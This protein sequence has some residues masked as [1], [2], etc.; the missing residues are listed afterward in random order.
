MSAGDAR[1]RQLSAVKLALMAKKLRA[2]TQS[3]MRAEPIA[4]VGLGCR[5]PGGDTAEEF[6]SLLLAGR[7][8]IRDVPGQ[9][10]NGDEW[11]DPDPAAPGKSLTKRGGFLDKVDGFDADYLGSCHEKSTTWILS[12]ACFWKLPWRRSTIPG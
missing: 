11:F 3:L 12:S 7:S 1:Y 10:W 6:W 2:E 5:V 4:V 8:M 9:R